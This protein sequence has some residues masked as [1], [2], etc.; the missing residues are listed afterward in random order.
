LLKNV[1]KRGIIS[2]K[3]FQQDGRDEEL[4]NESGV[5]GEE[6]VRNKI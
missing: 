5:R 6:G 3:F 2:I 4:G 1:P